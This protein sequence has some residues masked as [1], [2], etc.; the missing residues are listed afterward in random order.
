MAVEYTF[1]A[2]S[3]LYDL[4]AFLLVVYVALK[5]SM[6]QFKIPTM[7][8]VIA[9]DAARYFLV[10]FTSHL[11]LELTLIFGRPSIQLLPSTGNIVIL[12]VMVTRLMLSLKKAAVSQQEEVWSLGEPSTV[13][14]VRFAGSRGFDSTRGL[15]QPDALDETP[16]RL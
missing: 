1:P 14:G 9:R 12:P 2:I 11:A 3:L 15:I 13:S 10:I 16:D 4:L 8:G 6:Y 7:F 5:S